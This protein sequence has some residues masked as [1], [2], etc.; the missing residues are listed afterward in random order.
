MTQAFPFEDE[1]FR[2]LFFALFQMS[3][4]KTW[5]RICGKRSYRILKKGR[6]CSMV[7]YMEPLDLCL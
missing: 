3:I 1:T 7:G 2:H 5:N 6:H 4:L